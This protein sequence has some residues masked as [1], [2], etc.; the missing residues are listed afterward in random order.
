MQKPKK[1]LIIDDHPSICEILKH[2]FTTKDYEVSTSDDGREALLLS[3]SEFFNVIILAVPLPGIDGL[4][5]LSK[6]KSFSPDTEV[7]MI[8]SYWE[9]DT[10]V[11]SF[12]LG[13]YDYLKKPFDLNLLSQAVSKALEKQ[14]LE[15]EKRYL[16]AQIQFKNMILE[17]QGNLLEDKVIDDGQRIFQ[18]AKKELLTR[19]LFEETIESIP[20]GAMVIDTKGSVLMCNRVQE[21]FSGIPRD[22]LLGK[23]LFRDP[24]P[25]DLKP[26]QEIGRNFLN[27]KCH[28]VK[29]IDQRPAKER[30]LSIT[31][32]SLV[33]EIGNSKG[34]IFLSADITNEKR[35]EEQIIQSEKMTAIG[36][37]VTTL[38]HQ[39][40]NP[41]AIIGSATQYCDEKIKHENGLRKYFEIIYRNIQIA[42]KII[43]DLLDF[44]KPKRLELKKHDINQFLEEICRFIKVDF[45]KN[46]IRILR[47]FDKYVP[48]ILCDKESMKQVF[49]N[50]F[51]NSK[52]AMPNGGVVS[53]TT[54]YNH[55]EQ[56]IDIIVKDTGDGIPKEYL[57]NIFNPYFTTK[58]KGTGLGLSI[59]H[60][61]VSDHHGNIIP[62]SKE[63]KGTKMT[64]T[65]PIQSINPVV[66]RTSTSKVSKRLSDPSACPPSLHI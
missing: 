23:N 15:F 13:A 20:L 41:L 26:W 37:L 45:S 21:I 11:R 57:P 19:T 62:A 28:E 24:L 5:L 32:S 33:D 2:F 14:A 34:F 35:V 22:S 59:A 4:S 43:S 27:S 42:N 36:Q 18:L 7:I 31:F 40:R 29:V 65:L 17:E 63:G 6:I 48:E 12:K 55:E 8:T 56:M 64:I 9:A 52:Q 54:R 46:R 1:I 66:R 3:R 39:I 47:R 16:I 51:M 10:A 58:E 60:R 44:A 38:A 50:L 61:I 25:L 53:V 49:L 30:I